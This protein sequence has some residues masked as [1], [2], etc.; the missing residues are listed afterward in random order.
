MPCQPHALDRSKVKRGH[1]IVLDSSKQVKRRKYLPS[2]RGAVGMLRDTAG[3]RYVQDLGSEKCR[4]AATPWHAMDQTAN[5]KL[6]ANEKQTGEA[7]ASEDLQHLSRPQ[8]EKEKKNQAAADQC[9]TSF[10]GET[11]IQS[12]PG[13]PCVCC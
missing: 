2:W 10:C 3:N 7:D 11:Y 12:L 6:Q 4:C 1:M 8:A 9:G 13:P 5:Q